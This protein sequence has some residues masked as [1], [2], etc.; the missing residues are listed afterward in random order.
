MRA[1]ILQRTAGRLWAGLAVL[2]VAAGCSSTPSPASLAPIGAR[3]R[4]MERADTAFLGGDYATA[5]AEYRTAIS[6]APIW[7]APAGLRLGQSLLKLGRSAEALTALQAAERAGP[8]RATLA[9]ILVSQGD[10][11]MALRDTGAAAERY[12][13]ALRDFSDVV[14]QDQVQR[15]LALAEAGRGGLPAGDGSVRTTV[16]TGASGTISV[17]GAYTVQAGA[18]AD[19]AGANARKREIEKAGFVC[20][21]IPTTR[22][23]RTL[24]VIR[25][26]RYDTLGDAQAAVAR[27]KARGIS[28]AVV[29]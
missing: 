7:A 10:A 5:A 26:G 8:D 1:G 6:A 3:P 18:F 11:H 16:G 29:P 27:L 2:V 25:V 20:E 15:S 13:L 24:Y 17:P 9:G 22:D 4:P 14:R 19:P 28:A 12:R 23:G 21:L